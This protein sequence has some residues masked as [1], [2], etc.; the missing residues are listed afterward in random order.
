[1]SVSSGLLQTKAHQHGAQA[2]HTPQ[3]FSRTR[4]S[5]RRV[6]FGTC[7][8]GFS[9]NAGTTLNKTMAAVSPAPALAFPSG[10]PPHGATSI[11]TTILY[12]PLARRPISS[13]TS[14]KFLLNPSADEE[15]LLAHMND[16]NRKRANKKISRSSRQH[17]QHQQRS[18]QDSCEDTALDSARDLAIRN[19]QRELTYPNEYVNI[20]LEKTTNWSRSSVGESNEMALIEL[21][22]QPKTESKRASKFLS[23]AEVVTAVG[24]G[25]A[26]TS[27]ISLPPRVP[28]KSRR[29]SS[30]PTT[31]QTDVVASN[32]CQDELKNNMEEVKV[33]FAKKQFR[34]CASKC[35]QLLLAHSQQQV[36]LSFCVYLCNVKTDQESQTPNLC[37]A[38]TSTSTLLSQPISRHDLFQDLRLPS[39]SFSTTHSL[40]SNVQRLLFPPLLSR[41]NLYPLYHKDE[42]PRPLQQQALVPQP[43]HSSRNTPTLPHHQLHLEGLHPTLVNETTD[44]AQ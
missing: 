30:F 39:A 17:R 26:P 9:P 5:H 33:M 38:S 22:L 24:D 1:M 25:T 43:T 14:P 2:E 44:R 23:L 31:P 27:V 15:T 12:H 41:R 18:G 4:D 36:C 8:R 6:S 34:K 29:R 16:F 35:E 40:T 7:K 37:T 11:S 19:R 20:L 3:H 10:A 13:V 28:P 42:K 32:I 21:V